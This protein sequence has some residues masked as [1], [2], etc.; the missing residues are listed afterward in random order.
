M[1]SEKIGR[2]NLDALIHKHRPNKI[3][4]KGVNVKIGNVQKEYA[5]R[6]REAEDQSLEEDIEKQEQ[7]PAIDSIIVNALE[8]NYDYAKVLETL[9]NANIL[10]VKTKKLESQ[11]NEQGQRNILDSIREPTL[12]NIEE[13]NEN[14]EDNAQE[15]T[16]TELLIQQEETVVEKTPKEKQ[17]TEVGEKMPKEVLTENVELENSENVKKEDKPGKSFKKEEEK[18]YGVVDMRKEK[19]MGENLKELLP[20]RS[21]PHRVRVSSYYLNNRKK[22]IQKLVPMFSK[23]KKILS[24]DTRKASCEDNGNDSKKEFHLL[25]HQQVV[26]DYL[27]LFSPY[28][29]LLLYHGLGSGKTCSSIAIAEGMKSRKKIYVLTLASLKANF[30]EQLKVCGDPLYKLNQYWE[31]VSIEGQS[32]IASSL[33]NALDLP[34]EYIRRQN[35]AWM[36]NVKK[37]P[38]FEELDDG[39]KKA[40]SAQLDMMIRRKYIDINY[41]GLT[42]GQLQRLTNDFTENPFDNSVVVVDEV[43]NLVSRIVNKIRDKKKK[44]ISYRLYEYLMG[45]EN[46]RMVFLSGTPIIN[47]PNEIGVL[48]NMLRGYVK[49]WNFP[50]QIRSGSDK[51]E[52]DNLLSWFEEDNLFTYDYVQYSGDS[53]SITRNPFGFMNI[54]KGEDNKKE[55]PRK[56]QKVALQSKK[57]TSRKLPP[58]IEEKKGGGIFDDYQGVRL[59]ESGNMSDDQF[60]ARVKKILEKHGLSM[61]GNITMKNNLALPETPKEFNNLFV[62]IGENE[63]KNKK[64]FQ[65]RILGLTSY[66]RGAEESLYPQFV[67]SESGEIIH[68]E[69]IPMSQYQ[70]G[71]YEKV[72]EDEAVQEK[73][74]RQA[75]QQQEFKAQ[76]PEELFQISSTYKIASRNACNFVFPNPPGRPSNAKNVKDDN[77]EQD[78]EPEEEVEGI[79]KKGRKVMKGGED[80]QEEEEK[81]KDNFEVEGEEEEEMEDVS[82]AIVEKAMQESEEKTNME[83][84]GNYKKDILQ[85]LS[86]LKLNEKEYLT[87]NGLKI[88]S[89]KFLRILENIQEPSHKGLHLIYSQFRTLEGIG[90]FK[91]VLEANGFAEFKIRKKGN[92]GDWEIVEKEEDK[93]KPKFA[94][95]TGTETD[96]EKKIL[97]NVYNS[98]WQDVPHSIVHELQQQD[99]SNNFMGDAIKA[100]M[101][102][103]SGAEGINLKNT[104]FV[105]LVEPY[106]HNVRI[107]QVIGRARRI[108]SHQDLPEDLRT[109]QVF[110]YLATLPKAQ[111]KE[112]EQKHIQLRLRDVS[113]LT[114]QLAKEL[115]ESSKLGR[116][117]RN[118]EV[119]PEVITT[120]QMLFESAMVK[121]QVNDQILHAVKESAMDCQLY[122]SQN[123]DESLVCFN[124]GKVLSNAFG[125]YPTLEHDIAEK[126]VKDV[127]QQKVSMVKIRVPDQ[128]DP[129]KFNEYA[130]DQKRKILYSIEQYNRSK[131]TKEQLNPLG[132]IIVNEEGEEDIQFF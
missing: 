49:T 83:Y 102:T 82:T 124:Y 89:P 16:N 61:K 24:D 41:N 116:Y 67:P 38:N 92:E 25:V 101:I 36:V 26:R 74:S 95:H 57:N 63:M 64:V 56:S 10:S 21:E 40:V 88:Y 87:P 123:K 96:E 9:K 12:E 7:K 78:D 4:E 114:S 125:S 128:K 100:L 42:R 6:K 35:G 15:K 122:S 113:K 66:F 20:L 54:V 91:L 47:Y 71:V 5:K 13:D 86:I 11:M 53:I 84:T 48:F 106:W 44:S 131:I 110:M 27:N 34:L 19:L 77:E 55:A 119:V 105:H 70:F 72:R 93:G 17:N 18:T 52:R 107:E 120:D 98:K 65:K 73:K 80:S 31:F 23:Y 62:G 81:E 32:Q 8:P 29:G 50:I 3:Q 121:E 22:Y 103:A 37:E 97:L 30:F 94:L 1:E 79:K 28:R 33:S 60:K 104:R 59:N 43:H 111:T 76:N 51:P 58:A 46:A 2:F 115:D 108:C 90:I 68:V 132:K 69:N 130:L 75:Q 99:K 45:A 85:A 117:V 129:T 126:D 14:T 127:R 118:L 39:D 109:V 112:E